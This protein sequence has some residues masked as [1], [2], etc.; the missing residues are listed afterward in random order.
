MQLE[1]I[2]EVHE[3]ANA[4]TSQ[5]VIWGT[6]VSVAQCKEKFK[7]FIL[8]YIDENAEIDERFENINLQMPIYVQ[9]LEEVF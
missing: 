2:Q 9:K 4:A 8:R 7:Q 3:T 6:N 1:P 5:L